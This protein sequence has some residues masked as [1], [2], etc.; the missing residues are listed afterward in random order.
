MVITDILKTGV[1]PDIYKTFFKS[2]SSTRFCDKIMPGIISPAAFASK[3]A[4]S[5]SKIGFDTIGDISKF[6]KKPKVIPQNI[7]SINQAGFKCVEHL[8]GQNPREYAIMID[9]VSGKALVEG[10]GTKSEVTLNFATTNTALNLTKAK[11]NLLHGHTPIKTQ[12]S[13][14]TLPVSLQDFIVLNNTKLQKIT[15]LNS[16]GFASTLEKGENYIK[17]QPEAI[18]NLK[19]LYMKELLEQSPIEKTEPI[20]KLLKITREKT[21]DTATK[22]ELTNRIN[23]L[24]YQEGADIIID[25]FWK[26]YANSYGL[27]YTPWS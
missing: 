4:T 11:L 1:L 18:D 26:K 23:E 8:Q 25:E 15:A 21:V 9:E 10:I 14:M 17:L 6:I 3:P 16:K 24:Q 5:C 22:R 12:T 20:R 2:K 7:K 27:K 13:E 19:H